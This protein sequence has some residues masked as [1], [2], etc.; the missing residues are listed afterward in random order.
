MTKKEIQNEIA[1]LQG[2]YQR[3]HDLRDAIVD[4]I[5]KQHEADDYLA[6]MAESLDEEN[7]KNMPEWAKAPQAVISNSAN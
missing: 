7:R 6:I 4:D 3:A 1:K 5:T 2:D